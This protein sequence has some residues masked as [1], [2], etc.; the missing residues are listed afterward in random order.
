M[1]S[2]GRRDGQTGERGGGV[3]GG[4]TASVGASPSSPLDMTAGL[5]VSYGEEGPV[6]GGGYG[7]GKAGVCVSNHGI[8]MEHLR[9]CG[10]VPTHRKR[11]AQ[12][13]FR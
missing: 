2:G 7:R 13:R 1:C 5:F 4:H 12:G 3:R 10:D 11:G 9:D 8:N 6:W